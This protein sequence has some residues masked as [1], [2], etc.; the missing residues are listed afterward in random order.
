M[1][2]KEYRKLEDAVQNLI[3]SWNKFPGP[4]E[5]QKIEIALGSFRRLRIMGYLDVL[6]LLQKDF[7]PIRNKE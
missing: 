5:N 6:D 3:N 1:T 4:D 7:D 2:Y